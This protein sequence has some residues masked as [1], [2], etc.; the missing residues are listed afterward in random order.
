MKVRERR[1]ASAVLLLY[2]SKII[3][4]KSLKIPFIDTYPSTDTYT[5]KTRQGI[6]DPIITQCSSIG[7]FYPK[8]SNND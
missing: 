3:S 5:P 1:G 6:S 7:I 2:K 8:V 4:I